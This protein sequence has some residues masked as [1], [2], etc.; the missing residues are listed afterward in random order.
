MAKGNMAF[1]LEPDEQERVRILADE[2]SEPGRELTA[3]K[4][5]RL[6]VLRSLPL[7]EAEARARGQVEVAS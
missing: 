1:R 7:Y 3:S 5:L 4:M 2:M 6:L